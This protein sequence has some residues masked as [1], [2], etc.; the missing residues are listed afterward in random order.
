MKIKVLFFIDSF[1]IGG[2]HKQVLYLAK[3]LDREKFDCIICA[4]SS[5]G[6]F[7]SDYENSGA[8]IESLQWTRRLEIGVFRRFIRLLHNEQPDIIFI[9]AP[10]NLFYYRIARLFYRGKTIQ[11]G[12]FRA[13]NFWQG[14]MGS[15]FK[16][17]DSLLS[18]WMIL[19]SKNMA[20]NSNAMRE[21]YT[22]FLPS[23]SKNKIRVIYNGSDFNFPVTVPA[24]KLR[25]ELHIKETDL[26]V[27]MIARLDPW[28]DFDT[29]LQ[30]A[31]IIKKQHRRIKFLLIGDG[32]L[33]TYLE[34]KISQ[35][36]LQHTVLILS[37]KK[38]I[39]NYINLADISILS[40]RGEGFSNSILESMA[41]AKPVIVTD[42]GGNA[43]LVGRTGDEGF[44]SPPQSPAVFAEI[45]E[46][47]AD[48]E[49]LRKA[50]GS[51]AKKKIERLCNI[52]AFVGSYTLLFE[53]SIS[54][55]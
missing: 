1:R 30:A 5:A 38:D 4:Q 26:I 13:M 28:K 6:G 42:V 15:I 2:M 46:K 25:K 7:F 32:E 34:E 24:L 11:I 3:H 9:T 55:R 51:R 39:Y 14:H 47:M 36:A 49:N 27:T 44:L 22:R 35:M 53:Q 29:V 8:R 40:T 37:E 45:I 20:V 12:S 54:G 19:T 21:R 33:R 23:I 41:F 52:N 50:V 48:D 43:E 16:P 17:V 31:A 10:Q 18:R